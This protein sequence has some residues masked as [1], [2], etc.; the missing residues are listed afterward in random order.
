MPIWRPASHVAT[1]TSPNRSFWFETIGIQIVATA[2][3][4]VT[5]ALSKFAKVRTCQRT[6]TKKVPAAPVLTKHRCQAMSPSV[7]SGESA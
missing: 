4:V 1:A 2:S 5:A 7:S 3:H 6:R